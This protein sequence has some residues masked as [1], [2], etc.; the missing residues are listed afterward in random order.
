MV[1]NAKIWTLWDAVGIYGRAPTASGGR[2][3]FLGSLLNQ[4]THTQKNECDL[5]KVRR[6]ARE[7]RCLCRVYLRRKVVSG[8][9]TLSF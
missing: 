9:M 8:I 5:A 4:D 3:S 2:G 6:L 7:L 1:M